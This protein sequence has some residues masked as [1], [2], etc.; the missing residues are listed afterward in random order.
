MQNIYNKLA[1]YSKIQAKPKTAL[2][3]KEK[4]NFSKSITDILK[5]SKKKTNLKKR[6][7]V[8]L[9]LLDD[10]SY[11]YEDLENQVGS[12]SYTVEEY[13]E[14]QMQKF[15]DAVMPLVDIYFN[16]SEAY[17]TME[18][19]E[20]DR[21]VLNE[22][23]TNAEELGLSPEEVYP[24]FIDHDNLIDSLEYLD[25]KFEEQTRELQNWIK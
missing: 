4:F 18:D 2:G 6:K 15:R 1:K 24:E 20:T 7:K 16:N 3:K 25:G 22:I 23:R 12:L 17:P 5:L 19:V 11:G 21:D 13:F 14:E 8:N 9:A 10:F